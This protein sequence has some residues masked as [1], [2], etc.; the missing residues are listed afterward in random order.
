MSKPQGSLSLLSVGTEKQSAITAPMP[1]PCHT[2][3]ARLGMGSAPVQDETL[4]TMQ[5]GKIPLAKLL[6]RVLRN[7]NLLLI[8]FYMRDI[9]NIQ[10]TYP[11]GH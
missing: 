4:S 6:G 7:N 3:D 5:D 1:S 9:Q 8:P 10:A 2:P 11:S